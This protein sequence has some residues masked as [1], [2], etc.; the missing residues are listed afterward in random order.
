MI[1]K[2]NLL[3]FI[4]FLSSILFSIYCILQISDLN[5]KLK[6]RNVEI[7]DLNNKLKG[8]DVE[9]SDLKRQASDSLDF[10]TSKTLDQASLMET[11]QYIQ[12]IAFEK[13]K[14]PEKLIINNGDDEILSS[15][16][17][18]NI[19]K[20]KENDIILSYNISYYKDNIYTIECTV[21]EKIDLKT[22]TGGYLKCLIA[23]VKKADQG[24]E[25]IKISEPKD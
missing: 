10:A 24:F 1:K 22:L 16:I 25:L 19:I 15:I 11:L 4:L 18:Q 21:Y 23:E 13:R 12:E 7:S 14:Y 5:N 6:E 17:E 8:K 9:I 2:N 20:P 3:L